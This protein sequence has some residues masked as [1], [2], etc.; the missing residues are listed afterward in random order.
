MLSYSS[1]K[2]TGK[3][4]LPSVEMWGTNM[5]ILRDPPKSIYTR[6]IDKVSDTQQITL[7]EADSNDR[8]LE[9]I[10]VYAR[11]VNP[12]VGVSYNNYGNG[13]GNNRTN[14]QA[15]LPYKI[16]NVRPP[17][18]SQYDLQ[19]LSRL[20]RDWFYTFSNPEFPQIFDNLQCNEMG[21][22]VRQNIETTEYMTN[23]LKEIYL[24][25][26]NTEVSLLRTPLN[27][28]AQ[29]S[30]QYQGNAVIQENTQPSTN[31]IC[32]NK[33]PSLPNS[34]NKNSTLH[35]HDIKSATK[36]SFQS[37]MD[38]KSD[39]NKSLPFQINKYKETSFIH[40]KTS[41]PISKKLKVSDIESQKYIRKS[42]TAQLTQPIRVLNRNL[43]G[44]VSTT[45]DIRYFSSGEVLDHH[46]PILE[47][48]L[49]SYSTI[50]NVSFCGDSENREQ[51]QLKTLTAKTQAEDVH[52]AK[53]F[54]FEP[55]Q[56][57]LN[58]NV[59]LQK[60]LQI[61]SLDPT[62]SSVPMKY[63][64]SPSLSSSKSLDKKL[65]LKHDMSSM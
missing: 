26:S 35:N 32:T 40:P 10:N 15:S 8:R 24:P 16:E 46:L 45:K 9:N 30:V 7:Q 31:T 57:H 60:S 50:S 3:V 51:T 20:P 39:K 43:N 53:L 52:S 65:K 5:N 38:E 11:N 6:R 58:T 36:Y 28:T 19:P 18:L 29:T 34:I 54:S 48:K 37:K 47:S 62:P 22:C 17:L 25:N 56:S 1:L 42:D 21:K 49:P 12:M 4:T 23:K 44:S 13:G 59:A 2:T 14:Q 33:N 27:A 55:K 61:G 63:M 64:E 41:I